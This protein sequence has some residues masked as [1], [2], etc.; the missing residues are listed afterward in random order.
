MGETQ[1]NG[2]IRLGDEFTQDPHALFRRLRPEGSACPVVLP[3]QWPGWLVT[4]YADARNLLTDPRVKKDNM[5]LAGLLPP[6]TASTYGTKLGGHMLNTDP[7][8]HTR[9]RRLVGMAFTA[10]TVERLRPRIERAA[11]DLLDAI[12]AGSTVDLLDA[13]ALPLPIIVICELLGVPAA[14]QQDFRRWSLAIVTV[15]SPEVKAESIRRSGEYLASLI[16][17]KRVNPGDD[18]L[19]RLVQASDSDGGRLSS[20]ELLAMAFLLLV[21]GFETTANLIANGALTLLSNPDQLARLRA[22]PSLLPDAI[23]EIL[24]FESPV[25]VAT[26]R[27]T[28]EAVQAGRT[29]IPAKE[30]VHVSL[31]AANRDGSRFS[32][33]DTFDITRQAGGHIA[34]G[35]GIHHCVGAPLARL[36]GQIAIGR[37][38]SRFPDLAL[39]ADPRELRWQESPLMHGLKTL[40]VRT[41][42]S[43]S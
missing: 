7:P 23:E 37:L 28:S 6:G 11:A 39:G 27:F 31:L 32:D 18:L 2:P 33:P 5:E 17:S 19:S 20:D 16:Q 21:A 12:P 26:L 15:A 43:P 10:R 9:L 38:F 13:Y 42:S 1:A 29:E 24:R 41:G 34:F 36:E 35:H 4:S 14:D 8:A 30:I 40:P 3:T 25:N 22:E